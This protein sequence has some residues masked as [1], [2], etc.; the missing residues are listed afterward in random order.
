MVSSSI[1]GAGASSRAQASAARMSSIV[2]CS[3][4]GTSWR[5]TTRGNCG[6]DVG[7]AQPAVMEGVDAH[8][9]GGVV[10]R[11]ARWHPRSPACAGQRHRREGLVVER[12]RSA[13]RRPWSSRSAVSASGTRSGQASPD[14]DRDQ[15]RRRAELGDDAPST[16]STI[17]WMSCCGWTTTSMRSKGTSKSRCASITSRPLLTRVAEL[18]VITRPIAK[19][20]W[21]S[22]CSGVTSASSR[23]V[24]PRNGPPD[25]VSTRRRTS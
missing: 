25:A 21:A 8:L 16:N 14:R 2:N 24:R 5:A 7:E 15:H 22:A 17:E 18:V 10:D 11:R 20:G 3:F 13:S 6:H 19:L 23:G 9:V 12:A 4:K 1:D